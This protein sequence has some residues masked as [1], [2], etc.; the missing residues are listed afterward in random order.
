MTPPLRSTPH[1]RWRTSP[2]W[3][4]ST[5]STSD[6][7]VGEVGGGVVDR[8]VDAELTQELLVAR[9][10]RPGHT[11]APGLG[12]LHRDRADA[13]GRGVDEH[14]LPGAESSASSNA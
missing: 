1:E 14:E 6:R 11:R 10:G 9:P 5:T 4:S 3:L 7:T 13:A 12:Q 2:P 8:D